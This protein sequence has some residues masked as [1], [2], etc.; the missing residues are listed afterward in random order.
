M[1]ILFSSYHNY[2]D[3]YSG[4]AITT[5]EILRYLSR[6]GDEVHVLCG[7]LFDSHTS[8]EDVLIERMRSVSDGYVTRT[9]SLSFHGRSTS[10]ASLPR[11]S[12]PLARTRKRPV[13]SYRAVM[14][15]RI[16]RSL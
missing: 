5:R 15:T 10:E 13:I 11:Y 12:F 2:L 7:P 3:S 16:L 1:K 14:A 9:G 6:R 4:A 8:N